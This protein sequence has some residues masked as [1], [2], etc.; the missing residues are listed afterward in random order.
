M[1]LSTRGR[2]GTRVLMDLALHQGKEPVLLRDIAQR[3][4]IPLPYLK[5]LVIPLITG[6]LLRSS[7][8]VGGGV[9]LAKPPESIKLREVIRLLEGPLALV[10]C[11]VDPGVCDRSG[12]C[13]TQDIWDAMGKAMDGVLEYTTLRDLAELQKRKE[14]PE[15]AM[16][17]I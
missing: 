17:H 2:Y 14:Q 16:Y 9:S 6:G 15:A 11:I 1:K 7:R 12:F 3:Q 5:R 10:E 13:A 4:R 8:G